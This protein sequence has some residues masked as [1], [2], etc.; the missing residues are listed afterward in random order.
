MADTQR[1]FRISGNQIKPV[2]SPQKI[3]NLT[4]FDGDYTAVPGHKTFTVTNTTTID[5]SIPK[6]KS[7]SK[8]KLISLEEWNKRILP[9]IPTPSSN[10]LECPRCH[11]ELYD[12]TDP[13][14]SNMMGS[15]VNVFCNDCGFKSSRRV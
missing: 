15:Y 9:D 10:G 7:R 4:R 5:T 1:T 12:S 2:D 13:V 11:D 3:E 8:K 6:K 14:W